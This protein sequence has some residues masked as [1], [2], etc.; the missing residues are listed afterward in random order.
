M[1]ETLET[2]IRTEIYRAFEKLNA[3]KKL[4]ATIGSWGDTLGDDEILKLL[5]MWNAGEFKEDSES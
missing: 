4:L 2:Q 1:S 3:D 5:R